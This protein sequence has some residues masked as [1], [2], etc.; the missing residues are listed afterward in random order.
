MLDINEYRNSDQINLTVNELLEK[1]NFW[2]N[3]LDKVEV[4]GYLEKLVEP[5]DG[6]WTDNSVFEGLKKEIIEVVGLGLNIEHIKI[7]V[8]TDSLEVTLNFPYVIT[9]ALY[10]KYEAMDVNN[11][12]DKSIANKKLIKNKNI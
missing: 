1:N 8:G 12:I 10:A 2:G 11:S 9:D 4:L 7:S 6:I 5:R 3:F